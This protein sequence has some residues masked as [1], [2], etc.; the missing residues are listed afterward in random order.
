MKNSVA[1]LLLC[2]FLITLSHPA[3]AEFEPIPN[4]FRLLDENGEILVDDQQIVVKAGKGTDLFTD[5]IGKLHSDNV[6]RILFDVAG[7]F[8][9]TTKIEAKFSKAYDGAAILIYQDG[10]HWM[11][12]LFEKFRSGDL[13]VASTVVTTT[14]DDAYHYST[15]KEISGI[16]LRVQRKTNSFTLL[17]SE[18]GEIWNYARSFNFDVEGPLSIGFAAQAPL[19]ESVTAVFSD[20]KYINQDV[21]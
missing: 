18:D 20:I 13:G 7:D 6:P 17:Y 8:S 15:D 14:G 5:S 19:S 9:L 2:L 4:E 1:K 12:F 10:Q 3:V 16:F 21:E 11:K